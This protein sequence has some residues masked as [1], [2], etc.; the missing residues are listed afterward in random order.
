[1]IAGGRKTVLI[2]SILMMSIATAILGVL[3][4]YST[5]GTLAPVLL[6]VCRLLQ[7]FSTGGEATTAL[8][9]VAEHSPVLRRGRNIAPLISATTAA[10]AGGSLVAMITNVA[11]RAGRLRRQQTVANAGGSAAE[12]H[13][14]GVGRDEAP[15]QFGIRLETPVGQHDGVG[16]QPPPVP[17]DHAGD[18]PR[19]SP[20]ELNRRVAGMI[21][22]PCSQ[23]RCC[24]TRSARCGPASR[25]ASTSLRSRIGASM[26]S[27]S[28]GT[29][30]SGGVQLEHAAAELGR[31]A[32]G[33][34]AGHTGSDDHDVVGPA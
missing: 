26:H 25:Q 18:L 1:V 20:S 7:G 19:R 24:R 11:L 4:T 32:G 33:H 15:A 16:G 21:S 22:P 27:I 12:E 9:L 6:L 28:P 29:V 14:V 2:S 13:P 10:I 34:R 23:N 3:P 8:V 31:T 30:G 17:R 5:V